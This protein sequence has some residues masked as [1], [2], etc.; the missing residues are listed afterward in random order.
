M[1]YKIRSYWFL[2]FATLSFSCNTLFIP[3]RAEFEDYRITEKLP[4]DSAM[5]LVMKPYRDSVNKSMNE[6]IGIAEN[7]LDKNQ[8]E[9]TL[10]NFMADAIYHA[11]RQKFNTHID[12]AFINYGGIRITQLAKGEVTKGKVM[13]MI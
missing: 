4:Q 5:L 9:G 3:Q 7:T 6:V 12:A 13:N 8:P 10:G 1:N 2:F 11:G